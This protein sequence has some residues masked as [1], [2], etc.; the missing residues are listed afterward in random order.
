MQNDSTVY[1][2]LDVHLDSIVAAYSVGLARCR[3][4][5]RSGCWTRTRAA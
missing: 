5:D 3:A 1:V 4:W 2:D